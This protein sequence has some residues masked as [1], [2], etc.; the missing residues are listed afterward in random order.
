MI[1]K[2]CK[3]CGSKFTASNGNACYCSDY[4]REIGTKAVNRAIRK[5][6]YVHRPRIKDMICAK[7]GKTYRG[8][9]NS[10]YCDNC[11]QTGSAVMK[12]YYR[13]RRFTEG[14]EE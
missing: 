13:N 1:E 12:Q 6:N 7:C 14:S 10:R 4:C 8:H 9:F 5:R 2:R 3:I 11:L